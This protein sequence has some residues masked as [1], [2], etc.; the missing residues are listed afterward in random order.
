MAV[1][2]R[3]SL[4]QKRGYADEKS[5]GLD[6]CINDYNHIINLVVFCIL[7]F[8]EGSTKQDAQN[9]NHPRDKAATLS[10]YSGGGLGFYHDSRSDNKAF[11]LIYD[12][13]CIQT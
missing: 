9:T 8:V 11:W 13:R 4:A 5:V 12:V 1:C 2:A 3:V 6:H 7:C 10:D